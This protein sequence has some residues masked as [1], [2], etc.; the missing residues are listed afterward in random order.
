MIMNIFVLVLA[1]ILG[2]IPSA[3]IIGKCFCKLNIMEHG[4][5]NV[6]ATN[7]FRVLGPKY[8]SIVFLMDI[9]KGFLAAFIGAKVGG[10]VIGVIC[11]LISIVAH[12]LSIFI[13]FKGGKGV[14]TGA[15][16]VLAWCPPAIGCALVIWAIVALV[17]G[18]ISLA[19]IIACFFCAVFM[20]VF[21]AS[22][23]QSIICSVA[24]VFIIYKHKSNIKRLLSHTENHVDWKKAFAKLKK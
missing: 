1:Y 15:G 13:H 19:S 14:A 18:Y 17:S 3:Y 5:G 7:T 8:G 16:V 10:E 4:S 9:G 11:G 22:L 21:D 6:G 12:T 20:F 23:V 24:V 2:A